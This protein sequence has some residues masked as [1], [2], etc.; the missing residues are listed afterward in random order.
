MNNTAIERELKKLTR[1]Q[2][3][4]DKQLELILKKEVVLE[5][6]ELKVDNLSEL[7]FKL[8]DKMSET[9][10]NNTA[11][12]HDT[13]NIVEDKVAEIIDIIDS[14]KI[15]EVKPKRNWIMKLLRR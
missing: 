3:S 7:V 14:K 15:V 11:D 10:K 6:I 5:D 4:Q 8:R 9:E 12:N 1:R 13:K 2:D